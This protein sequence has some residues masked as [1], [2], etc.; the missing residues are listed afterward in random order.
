MAHEGTLL[1]PTPDGGTRLLQPGGPVTP[2]VRGTIRRAAQLA[3]AERDRTAEQIIQ[4]GRAALE[5]ARQEAILDGRA[6]AG[7]SEAARDDRSP[8]RR[9][10]HAYRLRRRRCSLRCLVSWVDDP[11]Q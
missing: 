7:Y 4:D 5:R 3:L 9:L 11:G 8:D 2:E 1:I 6:I 10:A